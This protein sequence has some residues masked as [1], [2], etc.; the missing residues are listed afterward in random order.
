MSAGVWSGLWHLS[1]ILTGLPEFPRG[2]VTGTCL[3][4][5]SRQ[6]ELATYIH[7]LHFSADYE[8][9]LS[10][11]PLIAWGASWAICIIEGG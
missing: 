9:L 4:L 1:R 6:E 5:R 8:G 11:T 2:Q 3:A 10:S 7:L